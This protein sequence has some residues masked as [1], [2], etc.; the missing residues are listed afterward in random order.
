MCSS[1]P[2]ARSSPTPSGSA[3]PGIPLREH[4]MDSVTQ[5]N[6]LL[7]GR[8]DVAILRVTPR[9][10]VA[11][12]TG[13][14]HRLLRLEPLV[15]VG[16]HEEGHQGRVSFGDRPLHV[17]GDPPRLRNL[18]R[19]RTV[20]DR[21]GATT[22]SHDAVARNTGRLQSLPLARSMGTRQHPLPR[23]PQLRGEVRRRGAA[24]VLARRDPAVLPVVARVAR[25]RR[26]RD[27]DS[28]HRGLGRRGR[29]PRLAGLR[30]GRQTRPRL[31]AG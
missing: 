16:R 1:C 9:M 28:P 8:L 14:R 31:V 23:V 29:G 13:W 10:K 27:D 7:Q 15:L 20:P 25:G 12:P 6:A 2:R 30:S 24:H 17:F 5:L 19:A 21:P 11:H 26:R 18:Q 22:R 4:A 3:E